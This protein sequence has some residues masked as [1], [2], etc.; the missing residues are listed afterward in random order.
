MEALH[1]IPEGHLAVCCQSTQPR[2]HQQARA[3]CSLRP[4]ASKSSWRGD[5][6]SPA[7]WEGVFRAGAWSE[8]QS[9]DSNDRRPSKDLLPLRNHDPGTES[10]LEGF[11]LI[12]QVILIDSEVEGVI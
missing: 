5:Y 8:K 2:S 7:K 10:L 1:G 11:G 3:V 9:L 12:F 6:R 4:Q